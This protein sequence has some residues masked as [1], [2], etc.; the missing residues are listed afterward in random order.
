M[1]NAVH[2]RLQLEDLRTRKKKLQRARL[3]A[4]ALGPTRLAAILEYMSADE[5][6]NGEPD[7]CMIR[8]TR[9]GSGAVLPA[10]AY[11][12]LCAVS[13]KSSVSRVDRYC[14][15]ITHVRPI[16]SRGLTMHTSS[17]ISIDAPQA[18]SGG[19][20][21]E[22]KFVEVKV[23]DSLQPNQ[24]GWLRLFAASGIPSGVIRVEP[25]T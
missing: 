1:D 9:K 21:F 20:D 7:L 3:C 5:A 25:D 8:A 6:R 13:P 2:P 22:I 24:R 17:T 12:T 18:T 14:R 19:L 16:R 10:D 15:P 4:L 23:N 11:S